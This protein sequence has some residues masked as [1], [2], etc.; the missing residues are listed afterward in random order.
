M[1]IELQCNRIMYHKLREKKYT[2]TYIAEM[3]AT[4]I[5][6]EYRSLLIN[7]VVL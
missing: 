2:T 6:I 7:A 4:L 1:R 3:L 5:I